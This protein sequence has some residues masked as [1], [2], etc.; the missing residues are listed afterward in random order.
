M[1]EEDSND[2]GG[3]RAM[4]EAFGTVKEG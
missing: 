2:L 4:L 1:L 3:L